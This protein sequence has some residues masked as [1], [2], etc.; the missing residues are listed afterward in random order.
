[1]DGRVKIVLADDHAMVR[2]GLRRVLDAEPDLAVVAE[3]GNAE[4]ALRETLA[5]RPRIVVLDLNMPGPPTVD[6]IPDLLKAAPGCAVLVLTMDNEPASAQAAMSAGASAYVLKEAAEV[7]LVEAIRAL[8]AGR[9]YLDPSLGARLATSSAAGRGAWRLTAVADPEALVGST[10]ADHR[11]DAV[12]GRGGMG[13]VFRATDLAL[14][15][16]VALKLIA[17]EVAGDRVFRARFEREARLAASIDHPHV[18]AIHRAGEEDG[19]PYLTMRYVDGP[20]LRGV[21]SAIGPLAAPRATALLCQIAAALDAAHALGLVHRDVKPTNVLVEARGPREQCFLADFGLTKPGVEDS[22]TRTAMPLGTVDYVAPEQAQ[23]REVDARADI[24]SLGCV[25]F[26]MLTARVPFDRES[27][28]A[29]LWSHV[30]EPPP[31]LRTLRPDLPLELEE[32]LER[33]LAKRP[34]DRPASAGE[35]ARS[36]AAAI[37]GLT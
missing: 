4:A 17:A 31:K 22:V 34:A 14:D 29:K 16:P 26:Y 21:V 2:G 5:H 32:V 25:F 20:D 7:E 10:F 19:V 27:D 28:L 11:L 30:N 37:G 9:T 15:R 12:L 36:V 3:A 24:Y 6:V 13:V 1:M 23:G 18:V 35:L 33:A 8:L